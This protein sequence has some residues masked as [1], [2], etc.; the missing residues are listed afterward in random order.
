MPRTPFGRLATLLIGL[1]LGVSPLA[2]SPAL[3]QST[4]PDCEALR[5]RLAEHA[6]LSDGVRQALRAQ[7]GA[8]PAPAPPTTSAPAPPVARADAIRARLEQIAKDRQVLEDQRLAA[9]VRFE[10]SRATQIQGQIQMIDT[11][12]ANLERELAALHATPGGSAPGT[13]ASATPRQASDVERIRCQDV[14]AAVERAVK[15]R[16]RELGAR[17]GQPGAVPLT[18]FKAQAAEQIARDLAGQFAA[19]PEAATQVGLLA[20]ESTG[21][22]EGF[23]DVPVPNVFRL[24]R[25]RSDGTLGIELFTAPG[26]ATPLAYGE[27]ARCIEEA[28]ARQTG[29]T[30]ADL[31]ATRPAG[32]MRV[33]AQSGQFADARASLLAGNFADTAKIEVG[34]ARGL[35]FQNYRGESVRLLETIAPGSS[36]LVTRRLVLLPKP[37]NQE[38]WEETVTQIRPISYWRTDVEVSTS[39]ETRSAAGALV[40]AR[41]TGTPV[42]LSVER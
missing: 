16:Q 15:I 36:G 5:Q 10:L 9:L 14:P 18:G 27:T 8:A 20:S 26:S 19:W 2:S 35:E 33:L 31:L 12:K 30:L 28:T 42:K 7:V 1:L 17:E 32:P 24:Y 25:Q 3:A 6:R 13:P 11:E 22:L 29:Q 21:S 4:S 39:R 34:A 23:V 37:N 40:G 41:V 38:Q